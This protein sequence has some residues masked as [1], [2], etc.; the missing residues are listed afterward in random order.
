VSYKSIL[1]AGSVCAAGLALTAGAAL[2]GGIAGT[3]SADYANYSFSGVSG[4]AD[5]VGGSAAGRIDT[6]LWGMKLQGNGSYHNISTTGLNAN[7]WNIGADAYWVPGKGRLGLSVGYQG[8]D[9][10]PSLK[11]TNYGAFAEW[12][13]GSQYT[14]A[15]KLGGFSGNYG[16]DGYYLGGQFKGYATPD[17][18]LSGSADYTDFKSSNEIDLTAKAEVLL[19]ETIPVSASGGYRYSEVSGVSGHMN[20][21]FVSLTWYCDEN[22]S[23]PSL[24]GRQRSGTLGWAAGFRPVA[25]LF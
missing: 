24:V 1:L 5:S 12:W 6:G 4:S 14:V 19:S 25:G 3:V 22:G 10:G 15:G 11:I 20:T 7:N 9:V 13:A 21:W 17:L 8:F 23:D 2:A 16:I 18:A